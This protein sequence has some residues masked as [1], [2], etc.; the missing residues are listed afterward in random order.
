MFGKY[1]KMSKAQKEGRKD[2]SQWL[3]TSCGSVYRHLWRE[4]AGGLSYFFPC[5]SNSHF[6]WEK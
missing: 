6:I 5:T 3:G 2:D 1:G 4:E